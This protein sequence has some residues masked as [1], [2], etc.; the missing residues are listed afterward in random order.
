MISS[1]EDVWRIWC[2]IATSC[3]IKKQT[4][5]QQNP[6]PQAKMCAKSR[7]D[8]QNKTQTY[9]VSCSIVMTTIKTLNP[10]PRAK[11]CAKTRC[12]LQNGTKTYKVS[13]SIEMMPLNSELLCLA[14]FSCLLFVCVQLSSDFS[15]CPLGWVVAVL[16]LCEVFCLNFCRD[17][18]SSTSCGTSSLGLF[19]N[20][21]E[22]PWPW[23][24]PIWD[25]ST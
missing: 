15:R 16:D 9:K 13:C 5:E 24:L 2:V 10:K 3:L 22:H 11:M 19:S 12:D 8:L 18:T 4:D 14:A 1:I 21:G 7:H 23:C 6:K 25:W 17:N 20:A